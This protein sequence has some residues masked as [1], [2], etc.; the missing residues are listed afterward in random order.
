ML[1]NIYEFIS[2][3]PGFKEQLES[4]KGSNTYRNQCKRIMEKYPTDIILDNYNI[5]TTAMSYIYEFSRIRG[6]ISQYTQCFYV[7]YWMYHELMKRGISC[8]AKNLY[9]EFLNE[10]QREGTQNTCKSYGA[11][12]NSDNHIEEVKYLYEA[13]L[14]LN[15]KKN[16]GE[17]EEEEG[18]NNNFCK[19]LKE[20]IQEYIEKKKYELFKSDKQEMSS[21]M[22]TNTKDI[23]IISILVTLVVLL[24]LFY[25]LKYTSFYTR[26]TYK[27]KS[28]INEFKNEDE[29]MNILHQY[30]DFKSISIN[31]G[32]N[33]V[34]NSD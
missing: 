34:Y 11:N 26:L 20:I 14:C 4:H 18:E 7:Y 8:A 25:V 3:F 21:S 27:L 31:N 28:K 17:E 15:K 22:Q 9:K 6:D 5:C 23:I 12:N 29:E 1:S 24:L 30:E 19:T 33:I 13:Y 16:E 10:L 2:S 32:Y